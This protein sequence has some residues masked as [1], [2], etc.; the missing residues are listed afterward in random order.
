MP[1]AWR[2]SSPSASTTWPPAIDFPLWAAGFAGGGV[3]VAGTRATDARQVV[4]ESMV[5]GVE[6]GVVG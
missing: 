1:L 2:T 4:S 3:L 6:N 5:E